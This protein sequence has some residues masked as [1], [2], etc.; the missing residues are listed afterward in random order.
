MTPKH[1][2]LTIAYHSQ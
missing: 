1:D 2:F